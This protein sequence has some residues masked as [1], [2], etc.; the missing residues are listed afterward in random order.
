MKRAAMRLNYRLSS[1]SREI[2]LNL[3]WNLME[4]RPGC[5][6][7]NLGA[8]P[9][10][11]S[12]V[13]LGEDNSALIEQPEQDPRWRALRVLGGNLNRTDMQEYSR[14]YKSW[15]PS[16]VILDGCRLPFRD[17]G[18]DVVFSNAV[19]EHLTPN[20]QAAMAREIMRVGRSWFVTT[21]NFW[22]PIEMHNKLPLLQFLPRAAQ[23]AIQKKLGTWPV[24][25]PINLL[26]ARQ[27]MKLLPGSTVRKV[28]VT[29]F[30]ETLI[31]YKSSHAQ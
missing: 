11:L 22:Y 2:K 3:F 24:S 28:Q 20:G 18:I 9:P 19:I 10:H 1:R 27:L 13:L 8:A 12:R 14:L 25:D 30:P 7:L 29:F 6:V 31:A 23:L 26:S 17:Q 4:P 5:T 15:G 21:P 16:A